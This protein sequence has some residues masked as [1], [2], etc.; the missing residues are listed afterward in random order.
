MNE[1]LEPIEPNMGPSKKLYIPIIHNETIFHA[2]G[3]CC[4][5]YMHN[6]K[7]PLREKGQG[8]VIHISD[9]IVKHIGQL[10]LSPAQYEENIKLPIGEQLEF[11]DACEIIYPGKNHNHFWIKKKLVI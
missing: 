1:E 4:H 10:T 2:N 5:V 6:G 9:F 3:L 7:I 8:C 11:I